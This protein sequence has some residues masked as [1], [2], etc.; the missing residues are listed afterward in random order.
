M[1][2][3]RKVI[4]KDWINVNLKDIVVFQEGP[5]LTSDLFKET[6]FPFLN[7]RCIE[8]GKI[9]KSECQFI[10]NEIANSI[11]KHFQLEE[12]DLIMSTSG[13][14]GKKAFVKK[15]DL[16]LLLNTSIIRFKPKNPLTFNLEF[17]NYL[18]EDNDFI[19][20]LYNQSTGS[21]QI[22]VGPSHLRKISVTIPQSYAEQSEIAAILSKL[23]KAIEQ[24]EQLIE[25]YKQ[26]KIGL[27]H[28]LLTRGI[29]ENGNIRSEETHKFKDSPL[30]RIPV[31]WEIVKLGTLIN[32]IDPQPDHRTPSEVE[33]GVPY[34]GI[35]DFSDHK[36]F[37]LEKCRK[38][39]IDVLIKQQN[40]FNIKNG[41]L[42][43]GKIGTIGKPTILPDFNITNFALSANVIL[44]KPY[45]CP[46]FI[47]WTMEAKY[48]IEQVKVST[49][50]TSQ[51]AFGI[52]KIRDLNVICPKTEEKIIVANKLDKIESIINDT[53]KELLK[54]Q[55]QR[56]GLMH[57]LLTGKVRVSNYEEQKE[58][59]SNVNSTK[60][61]TRNQHI[62]DAVLI[63]AIVNAFYSDK[64]PLGRKKVQKLLYLV[65]RHQESSVA[66]FK[67][68]AAGPYADEVRY[69]GGEPIAK[70]NKYI[71][72]KTNSAGTVFSKGVNI[73]QALAY[74]EKWDMKSDIEWLIAQFKY[75]K[76]DQLELFATI[77]IARCD[78]EKEGITISLSTVKHLIATNKEWKAKLE[79]N[80]FDDLSIQRGID[81]SYKL[82]G[83]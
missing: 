35:S 3:N 2:D 15:I 27:M 24:T 21:A 28:D 20:E 13:T 62:E 36:V 56:S 1:V 80:Y 46:N 79:K 32:A 76:V 50:S 31:E 38:V 55:L 29:D 33:N 7:I 47:Y 72:T 78:L 75:T 39:S 43:F 45:E 42:I 4:L 19:S 30:G 48:I 60:A 14:L 70:T 23:D 17:L 10:S 64:Y 71:A 53:R 18:L 81:E 59:V 37:D 8:N 58:S 26:I 63:A 12:D 69:K 77:D 40:S 65:R 82:F 16:P 68:K 25:K 61:Q 66:C 6:G 57:D 9:N 52:Q 41:D 34:L 51:P 73:E 54:L 67:K 22:N 44:L 5:G 49:H 11:Y 74:I 83:E